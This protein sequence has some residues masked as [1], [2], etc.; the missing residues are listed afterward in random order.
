MWYDKYGSA[1]LL[2]E[3]E[4]MGGGVEAMVNRYLSEATR[5]VIH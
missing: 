4:A 5:K 2:G 1:S 3:S